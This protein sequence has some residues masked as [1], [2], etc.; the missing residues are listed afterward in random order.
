MPAMALGA[1]PGR[2]FSINGDDT[3]T[4]SRDVQLFAWSPDPLDEVR[5]GD[6]SGEGWSTWG[7]PWSGYDFQLPSGDGLQTAWCQFRDP[8]GDVT[9]Y[10][11]DIFLDENDP[12]TTLLGADQEWY[13]GPVSLWLT[14]D[15]GPGG[16]GIATIHYFVNDGGGWRTCAPGDRVDLSADGEYS[17][18]YYAVDN[19][20]RQEAWQYAE[21][22][23]DSVAPETRDTSDGLPHASFVLELVS[24][25]D[26]SGVAYTTYRID[27]GPWQVG[28]SVRLAMFKQVRH[29]RPGMTAGEHVIEYCST[30]VA[31][32]VEAI[33]ECQVILGD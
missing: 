8:L 1:D 2:A 6:G 30:D 21:V 4:L 23:I 33:R 14:A 26:R 15:D 5:F 19:A 20:G 16:S 10:S 27:D 28:G 32:N 12:V 13:R 29:K 3:Y 17:I 9:T 25:D 7:S 11:D 22:K 24:S 31:G 18:D